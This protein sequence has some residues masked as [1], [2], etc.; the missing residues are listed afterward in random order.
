MCRNHL[1]EQGDAADQ[2]IKSENI[3]ER[4]R[5]S[6]RQEQKQKC[7]DDAEH[8]NRDDSAVAFRAEIAQ[9]AR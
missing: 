1:D 3:I 9:L 7:R 6:Q 8:A 2:Q 4:Q 5:C